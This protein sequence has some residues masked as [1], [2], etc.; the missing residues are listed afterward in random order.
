MVKDPALLFGEAGSLKPLFPLA[1]HY[2]NKLNL[3]SSGQA[4]HHTH[5]PVSSLPLPG[6]FH[7][8]FPKVTPTA[9]GLPDPW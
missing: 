9:V 8:I 3:E 4:L 5:F 2:P 7:T 1:P 6:P